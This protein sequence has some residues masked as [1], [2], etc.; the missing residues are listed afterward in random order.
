MQRTLIC[1]CLAVLMMFGGSAFA[2]SWSWHSD[3][4]EPDGNERRPDG[5]EFE[6]P[7]G[8]ERR[9]DGN[10]FAEPDGNERRPDGNEFEEPDGNE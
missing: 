4:A 2:G 1:G 10:E 6:E 5:N 8:N 7:D 9:P 3:F